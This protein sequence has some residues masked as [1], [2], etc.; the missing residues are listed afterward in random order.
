MKRFF[1]GLAV[2]FCFLALAYKAFFYFDGK[3][4]AV[5]IA[6][7]ITAERLTTE[8]LSQ[9]RDGDIIL[10]RGFGFFSD[11]IAAKLNN[12]AIDVTHAGIIVFRG[13]RPFVIHSLSSDVSPIDGMQEQPLSEFLKFSAPGKIII[14]RPK[15]KNA[16]S[17]KKI[18]ERAGYYLGKK[19]PFDHSGNYDDASALFCTELIWRILEKDLHCVT[20]PAE[21]QERKRFFYSMEPMYSPRYFDI[22]IST[23]K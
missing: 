10:R 23:Y 21:A 15:G 2:F 20:L 17:G 9:L 1:F 12:G 7:Y 18:A 6:S 4:E 22:V 3:A 19:L 16:L 8:E 13:N 14:T 5:E 11:Y